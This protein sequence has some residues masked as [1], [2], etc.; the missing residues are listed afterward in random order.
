M[1]SVTVVEGANFRL[2]TSSA[3]TGHGIHVL[4]D[5]LQIYWGHFMQITCCSAAY[6]LTALL[7]TCVQNKSSDYLTNQRHHVSQLSWQKILRYFTFIDIFEHLDTLQFLQVVASHERKGSKI[8][9][10]F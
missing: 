3:H 2:T 10:K 9:P 6:T 8:L 7:V 1:L 5:S 4:G